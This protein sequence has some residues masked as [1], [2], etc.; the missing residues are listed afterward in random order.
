MI[1]TKGLADRF[2]IKP[3]AVYHIL[4]TNNIKPLYKEGNRDCFDISVIDLIKRKL[5][6][7]TKP[8]FVIFEKQPEFVIFESKMN[9]KD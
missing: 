7:E 8:D 1:T 2:G 3:K 9:K 5:Y 4:K 6:I